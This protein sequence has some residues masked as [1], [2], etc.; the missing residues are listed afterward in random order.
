MELIVVRWK[1][2]VPMKGG[3]GRTAP[4][5][6]SNKHTLA[7]DPRHAG[8]HIR[9]EAFTACNYERCEFIEHGLD[10]TD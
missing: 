10:W 3:N 8:C 7:L 2:V 4:K 5:R 1:S 9:D 6:L